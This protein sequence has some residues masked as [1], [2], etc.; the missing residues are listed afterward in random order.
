MATKPFAS[1]ADTTAKK[2]TL[3]ALADGVYALTAEGDPNIGAIE[4][5]DF[6]VCFEALATPVVAEAWLKKLREHTKKPVRYLLLSHYHAVRVL[7]AA[8]YNAQEIVATEMTR[9]LVAER[10]KQDWD[11]EFGRMPRL[12]TGADSVKGL[13]WPT[14]TFTDKMTIQLGGKRGELVLMHLGR[15]HTEGDMVAWLPKHK[16]LFAGDAVEAEAALYMG[17]SFPHEWSTTTLDRI[18]ALGAETLIGGRGGISHGRKAADAAI[19]QTRSFIKTMMREVG[20]VQKKKGTLKQAFDQAHGALADRY[21]KWPIFEHC[22]PFNVSRVWDEMSGIE[23]PVIWTA[24]R[25]RKVW[26]QLQN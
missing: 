25:D 16:I 22:M 24:E 13:T 5:E 1:T 8:A 15:G 18:K 6:V 9:N 10:G 20:M 17:D 21:G 14:L 19:E 26:D 23:R 7:G 2:Q 3:E 11:S 4:G 12:A